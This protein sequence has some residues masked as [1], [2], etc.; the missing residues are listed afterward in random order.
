VGRGEP[1]LELRRRE[2]EPRVTA[3]EEGMGESRVQ[4]GVKGEE[5]H[6]RIESQRARGK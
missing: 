4:A 3:G 5:K 6:S 1:R 2:E